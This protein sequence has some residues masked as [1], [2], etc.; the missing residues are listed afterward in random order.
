[1]DRKRLEK[2]SAEALDEEQHA[3][4]ILTG[5]ADN[6]DGADGAREVRRLCGYIAELLNA[7][8]EHDAQVDE[9]WTQLGERDATIAVMQV[10]LAAIP[11]AQLRRQYSVDEMTVHDFELDALDVHRWL[12]SLDGAA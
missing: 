9:L 7:V 6:Y 5:E 11:L 1:M 3:Y 10:R 12:C 4:N 2:I 8:K